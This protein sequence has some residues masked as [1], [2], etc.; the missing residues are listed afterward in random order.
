MFCQTGK[1]N[2]TLAL[3]FSS[4][5]CLAFIFMAYLIEGTMIYE[6]DT[7]VKNEYMYI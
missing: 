4:A 2:F 5:N 3:N 1:A 7:I 6:Q